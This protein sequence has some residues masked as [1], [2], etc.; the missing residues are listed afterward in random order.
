MPARIVFLDDNKDLREL[1]RDILESKL[2]VACTC[3]G[4]VMEFTKH[5]E[6]VLR[7]KVAILDINLGQDVPSGMDAFR[8]LTKQGFQ[9]KVVFFTGHARIYLQAELDDGSGTEV[10]EKPVDLSKLISAIERALNGN[11]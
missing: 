6:E 8:W 4:S 11:P 10:L 2:N 7:A 1:M 5:G 9:G 3:F